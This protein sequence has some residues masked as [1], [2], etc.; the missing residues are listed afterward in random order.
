MHTLFKYFIE[1]EKPDQRRQAY[2]SWFLNNFPVTE[3]AGD[4]RIMYHFM[5]F[6]TSLNVAI[7]PSYFDTFQNAELRGLLKAENIHVT[8]TEQLSY[9]DINAFENSVAITSKVL[10]DDFKTLL[11]LEEDLDDFATDLKDFL[12]ERRNDRLVT[13]L[14]TTF[15][16]IQNGNGKD[17]LNY[18]LN[19]TTLIDTLYDDENLENIL[20]G[21]NYSIQQY[22]V[23]E[24]GLPAIDSDSGGLWTTKLLGIEAQPGT[25]KTRFAVDISYNAAVYEN[26]NVVFFTLEQTASDIENMLVAKHLYNKFDIVISDDMLNRNQVPEKYKRLVEAARIDLFESKRYGK[27]VALEEDFA[28]ETFIQQ[29]KMY[30]RLKGPF[31]L[32]VIDY[33]G[34]IESVAGPYQRE[35]QLFEIV[36]SAFKQFKRYVRKSNKAGIAV[37]QFNKEGVSAGAS[38]K[39]ITTSMAEG[40]QAVYR[41]TDYNIAI[42][43]TDIMKAQRRR[44]F[45]QPKV[46]STQGFGTII[47]NTRL[48]ICYFEQLE[49]EV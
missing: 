9:I 8:G 10:Q 22:K 4:E 47:V 32:I 49:V 28:V 45:S 37:S 25:G 36:K 21:N 31:D 42:S 11:T 15:D 33:M 46:R 43:M 7:K 13:E 48:E 35:K 30:D 34:L 41:N 24:F 39:Q 16:K 17:A 6:C 3:F 27:L 23:A 18:L 38:D 19:A 1:H 5:Q 29:I 26:S 12:V 44:R 14:T 20:Q 2:A 40:G